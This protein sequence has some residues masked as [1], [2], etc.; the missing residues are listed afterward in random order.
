MKVSKIHA[1]IFYSDYEGFE[2]K[3][4]KILECIRG[5]EQ[6]NESLKLSGLNVPGCV[7]KLGEPDSITDDSEVQD[8]S[9]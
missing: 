4:L 3:G 6:W 2:C 8:I 7:K 1:R 9:N 5:L